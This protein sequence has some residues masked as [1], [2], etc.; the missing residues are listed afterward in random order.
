MPGWAKTIKTVEKY[1]APNPLASN[2]WAKKKQ[3]QEAPQEAPPPP[4][5]A[6]DDDKYEDDFEFDDDAVVI[7]KGGE[8]GETSEVDDDLLRSSVSVVVPEDENVN[9]SV[10]EDEEGVTDPNLFYESIDENLGGMFEKF[11]A[12]GGE[13]VREEED[14]VDGDQD[15]DLIE[16]GDDTI[17]DSC[18]KEV[19]EDLK[20]MEDQVRGSLSKDFRKLRSESEEASELGTSYGDGDVDLSKVRGSELRRIS[21]NNHF[22]F[23]KQKAL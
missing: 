21:H 17:D 8:G 13:M 14:G 9:L 18:Y 11:A 20:V 6:E 5:P 10:I 3:E 2:A 12:K 22:G 16:F 19:M 1:S 15:T 23:A 4:P 7:Q